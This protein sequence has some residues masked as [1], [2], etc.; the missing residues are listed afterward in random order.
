MLLATKVLS[1]GCT[2]DDKG[3]RFRKTHIFT[4]AAQDKEHTRQCLFSQ[5]R[6]KGSLRPCRE[7]ELSPRPSFSTLWPFPEICS[8]QFRGLPPR[9]S[10]DLSC[11]LWKRALRSTP[12][13][14]SNAEAV[15]SVPFQAQWHDNSRGCL[16]NDD[17]P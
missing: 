7:R 12:S 6:P 13:R 8:R 3:S 15:L 11:E 1:R 17:N 2:I 9:P 16:V 10:T 4:L 14:T 5:V